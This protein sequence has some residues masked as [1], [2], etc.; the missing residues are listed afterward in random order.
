M[1]NNPIGVF[2]SGVGGLNVLKKCAELMPNEKFIYLADE[3]N[4]PYGVKPPEEIKRYALHCASLLFAMNCKALV[5]ACNTATVT[6]I[7]CIR[8]FYP[9][10]I[11]IGLEPAVKPCFRELGRDG[12]AV[13]LVTEATSRSA[14]FNRLIEET[15]GRVKPLAR[16]ELA[17]LIEDNSNNIEALRPHIAEIFEQ[18]K[19]AEAVILGCSHYTY[20]TKLISDFYGGKIKIYDGATGEAERLK[21]C[22]AVAELNAPAT[23]KGSVRFYSTEKIGD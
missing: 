6:T 15:G 23:D 21:Y 22:L 9:D 16:K 19:T 12:Y 7:D 18:Y 13:A 17:K 1:R 14:K 8:T 5:I 10:K 11:V 20:I 2:D 4:M 3:A